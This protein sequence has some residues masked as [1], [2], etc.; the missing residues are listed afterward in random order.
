MKNW[1]F[2]GSGSASATG[3]LGLLVLRVVA[4]LSMA[5]GHGIKKLPPPDGFVKAVSGMGMPGFMAWGA[6]LAEFGGGLLIAIG[7]FTRPAAAL[8]IITMLVALVGVH[9]N[10][11]FAKQE[12][13]LLYLCMGLL[14]LLAGPGRF[15]VDRLIRK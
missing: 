15:A 14:F 11:P 13:A 9:R 6:T 8:W 3:D 5:F 4:G 1:I 10:D 7:L 12:M 2:G